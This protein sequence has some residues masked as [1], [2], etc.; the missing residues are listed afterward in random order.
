LA[1]GTKYQ[2]S[3]SRKPHPCDV[4]DGSGGAKEPSGG[5]TLGRS[6][7]YV[8]HGGA[9]SSSF[10]VAEQLRPSASSSSFVAQQLTRSPS[11][12]TMSTLS[13]LLAGA[14][15]DASV[16]SRSTIQ[17]PVPTRPLAVRRRPIGPVAPP[18]PVRKAPLTPRKGGVSPGKVRSSVTQRAVFR[19]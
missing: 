4:V 8:G 6:R 18:S 2:P 3:L 5:G 14:D 19:P 13:S 11:T 17:P 12:K 10:A 16:S 9:G 1:R 15:T 7:S